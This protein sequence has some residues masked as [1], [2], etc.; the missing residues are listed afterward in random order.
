MELL[1]A[2]KNVTYLGIDY[3]VV[4]VLDFGNSLL[5]V[6]EEDYQNNNYPLQT[7]VIPDPLAY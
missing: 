6:K 3:H 2:R 7:Y 1:N 5:V 4:Q